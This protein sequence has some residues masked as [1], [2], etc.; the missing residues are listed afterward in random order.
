MAR[1]KIGDIVGLL[2]A[3][4]FDRSR[5]ALQ[6]RA[7]VLGITVDRVP[8]WTDEEKKIALDGL[9]A[10]KT[11]GEIREEL[12]QAGYTRG[13]TA[14]FK[15][16]Q[17][18]RIVRKPDRWTDDHVAL[19]RQRYAEKR[20]VKEIAAELGKPLASVRS[21]ASQLGLKVRLPWSEAERQILVDA[22][23]AGERLTIAA[24]RIARPY[25]NVVAEARRLGLSFLKR[26]VATTPQ[27][28]T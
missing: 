7:I 27:H 19:L 14:M 10:G 28:P 26:T 1:V 6:M 13:P 25:P 5:G 20:P 21:R 16:A 11:H 18:H 23:A 17:K 3:E 8:Y 15:F 12:R 2:K 4:G 24:E 22:H 9:R